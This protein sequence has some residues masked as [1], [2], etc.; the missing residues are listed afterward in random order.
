MTRQQRNA[1]IFLIIAT[2]VFIVG[3]YL[4]FFRTPAPK[5]LTPG[6]VSF[7]TAPDTTTNTTPN[8]GVD[9]TNIPDQNQSTSTPS[10][11]PAL[12]R[13][14][15]TPIAGAAVFQ[16]K[17]GTT[18]TSTVRYT[19]RATG[20]TYETSP[21]A[22]N[23]ARVSNTTVAKIQH[24]W[25][26][27]NLVLLQK[28]SNDNQSVITLIGTLGAISTTTPTTLSIAMIPST[29]TA[30]AI[31]PKK[32]RMF[33]IIPT[34]GD[35]SSKGF[36]AQADATKPKLLL[37]LPTNEWQA[38]W[39]NENTI[40]LTTK[41][42]GITPGYLYFINTTNGFFTKILG[43]LTG[44]TT[45]TNPAADRVLY[46]ETSS[47]FPKTQVYDVK[48]QTTLPLIANTFAEKC[49][50]SAKNKDLAYCAIPDSIQ[51]GTYPDDWYQGKV[52][53]SDDIY[54]FDLKNQSLRMLYSL[55]KDYPIDAIN[56][57]LNADENFLM[58]TN[59]QDYYLWGLDLVKASQ[60]LK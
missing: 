55:P 35:I 33:F 4:L 19:D 37:N 24:A 42:T 44:L 18:S 57:F 7:G 32:N 28:L 12:N 41:P 36:I 51:N 15:I 56:L 50:W 58:F 40:T 17:I 8:G 2:I 30:P 6:Q 20:N 13:L 54:V 16:V 25:W 49:V 11:I 14:S 3:I 10:V 21:F 52:L 60:G 31:S 29:I 47:G 39:P 1:L 46:T 9:T 23:L 5:A 59:K 43:D 38:D 22:T 48:K 45:L 53:F 34:D 27:N 26:E